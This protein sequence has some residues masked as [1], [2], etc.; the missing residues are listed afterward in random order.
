MDI[1]SF[2]ND[3]DALLTETQTSDFLQISVRTLQAKRVLG[4]GPPFVKLGRA[5]RYRRSDLVEWTRTRT[6]RS[7]SDT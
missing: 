7:T 6:L 1:Q 3:P 4:G 5:V 2:T